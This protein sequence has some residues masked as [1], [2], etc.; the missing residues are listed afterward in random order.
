M[1]GAPAVLRFAPDRRGYENFYLVQP[2]S[3][4]RGKGESRILYWFRTPPGVKVGRTPF[5]PATQRDIEAK[6]PGVVFDWPRLIAT[7]IPPP[8]ADVERWRERRR[9][10][11]AEKAARASRQ[12]DLEEPP[13]TEPEE[14]AASR[15]PVDV[16]DVPG[17]VT[18]VVAAVES[19]VAQPTMVSAEPNAQGRRRRRRRRRHRRSPGVPAPGQPTAA[20]EPTDDSSAEI[21]QAEPADDGSETS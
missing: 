4:R 15:E 7:P 13:P 3:I 1:S 17:D 20:V 9:A 10:E 5:D 18:D 12:A 11:K 8:A 14:P 2:G 21:H 6:N 19:D 16:P